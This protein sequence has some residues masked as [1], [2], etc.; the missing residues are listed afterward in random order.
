MV[1]CM[2]WS[3]MFYKSGEIFVKDL[4]EM[5]YPM[6]LSFGLWIKSSNLILFILFCLY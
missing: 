3:L 4:V 1:S 5:K 2:F 6:E